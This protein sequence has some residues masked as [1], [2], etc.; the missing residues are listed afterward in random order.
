M[1]R[2]VCS[3]WGTVFAARHVNA[4][5]AMLARHLALPH[6]LVCVTDDAAGIDPRV[7]IVPMPVT[8]THTPR[9]RRRMQ[10]Y[11][12]A[13]VD[14]H[15]GGGRVLYLDL[16]VVI[17]GDLTPLVD[18]P[19]PLIVWRVGHAQVYSGSF[20]VADA[21]V[22]DGA[23]QRFAADPEGYPRAAEPRAV[24]SDQAMINHWLR[25][26]GQDVHVRA[27]QWSDRD[28]LVT[29]YGAGYAH[30]EHFGVGPHRRALPGGARIVVL[31]S[32]D[33]YVLQ[34]AGYP[35]VKQHW[36]PCALEEARQ[37]S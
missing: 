1:L 10:F 18:R 2:V 5:R 25:T 14:Q 20:L 22:L 36:L 11:S 9:C 13:F 4:L 19:A 34:D 23:W 26:D 3:K 30:L 12:R 32:A 29:F 33:L 7:R 28:G 15:L 31:G 24:G 8:Y 37:T 35:W 27:W 21:G 17:V 6:E 16:D